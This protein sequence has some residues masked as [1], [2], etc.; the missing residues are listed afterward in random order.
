MPTEAPKTPPRVVCLGGGW[1]AIYVARALRGAIRAGEVELTVISRDNFHTFHG[2]IG[3]MITGKI[4]PGQIASPSRRLFKGAHFHNAEIRSIDTEAKLITASRQMDGREQEIPYDHL[5]V[6]LGSMEDLSRYPGIAQHTMTLNRYSD[7]F[8]VRNHLLA[9]LEMAEIEK[10]PVE[11]A[12]LLTFVV[13]GAGFA[14]VEVATEME[15]YFRSLA[16]KEYSGISPEEIRVVLVHSGPRILPE[17]ATRQPKL[18]DYAEKWLAKSGLEVRTGTRIAAATRE[19]AIFNN[20]ER[21]STRTIISCAGNALSPLLDTL[22]YSRDERGRLV[23]DETCR[24]VGTEDVWA[25]GD[26]AAVPHPKGE[27]CPPL[28]IY[29]M[30]AG[31]QV[32]RNISRQ[33]A[34][35]DL[36]PFKFTG[37]GDAC[38]LG[39]HRAVSHLKGVRVTGFLA[40]VLWRAFFLYYVPSWDRKLRIATDWLVTPL[41]GRNIINMRVEQPYGLRHEHYE[42]GQLV[43]KQG[44]VGQQI[45]VVTAGEAEIVRENPEGEAL[46]TTLGPGDHFGEVSVF[47]GGRRTASVRALTQ[48]E[49]ISLGGEEALALAE[50]IK[51]FGDAIKEL[52]NEPPAP[53]LAVDAVPSDLGAGVTGQH[54]VD[55][56]RDRAD[57]DEAG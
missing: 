55:A 29:A 39:R 57:E 46:V 4:A 30:Y 10:D 19:E 27:T 34:G 22:P 48:L 49:L 42:P 23:T 36:K 28:A 25:A 31:R 7:D 12:R 18:V 21:I 15:H 45:Y 14:G 2:F 40:W 6:S 26:C 33:L 51:T 43:V 41:V 1:V 3:E 38:S 56:G 11:R 13:V 47:T 32:G 35:K 9:M 24:V 52:P 17:L 20:G 16:R 8:K 50:T 44:D 5:V 53:A 54:D 37:L